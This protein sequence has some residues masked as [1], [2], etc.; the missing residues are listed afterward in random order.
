L[1]LPHKAVSQAGVRHARLGR[2]DQPVAGHIELIGRSTKLFLEILASLV[3]I[4]GIAGAVLAWRLSQGPISLGFLTPAVESAIN[5]GAGTQVD[6]GDTVLVWREARRTLDVRAIGVTVH[7]ADGRRLAQLP[8]VA[9]SLSARALLRGMIAPT[10]LDVVGARITLTRSPDGSFGLS[11]GEPSAEDRSSAEDSTSA[12]PLLLA[13]LLHPPDPERSMGYLQEVSV[14]E[15]EVTLFDQGTG[16][17]WRAPNADVVMTR[18][19]AGIRAEATLVIDL[20]GELTRVAATALYLAG[21]R[22]IDV[23]A[24]TTP[25]QP[26]TLAAIDP[27]L[28]GLSA[29]RVPISGKTQ[30]RL[31][32]AGRLLGL[33]FDIAGSAGTL[34]EPAYFTSDIA[35][36]RLRIR[37]AATAGL[38]RIDIVEGLLDLGGPT[39]ELAAAVADLG[40]RPRVTVE[41]AVRRLPTNELRKLWPK[42]AAEN[43]RVWVT[44]NLS[45]GTVE[46]TRFNV[47]LT[48]HDASFSAVDAEHVSLQFRFSG[49]EV[50][51]LSPMPRVRDV[52]GTG[53]MGATRLDLTVTDGGIDSLRVSEGKIAITDFE[54]KD[55]H[56]EI[57]LIVRGPVQD[58]MKLVDSPPL[59][60]VKTIGLSP[61][62][63]GGD[64][65]T[66]LR[67]R[68]PLVNNLKLDQL[69][70]AAAANIA[71]FTQRRAVLGQDITDGTLVLRLD[72][73]GM[74]ISGTVVAAAA[75]AEIK[76][77]RNFLAGAPVIA[78][79]RAKVT[80]DNAARRAFGLDLGAYVDGPVGTDLVYTEQRGRRSDLAVDLVL[81]G[82]ALDVPELEWRKALGAAGTAQLKLTLQNERLTEINS[83]R[84]AAG[85]LSAQGRATFAEDGK[86]LRRVDVERIKAG[87]TDAKGSYQR[88]DEGIA[89]RISG[90]SINVGPF[91]R[92]RTAGAANRPPLAVSVDVARVYLA[93]DRHVDR[94]GLEGRR[95]AE[96]WET[97]DLHLMAGGDGT[98]RNVGVA[99]RSEGAVQRLN[100]TADDA[101]ALLRAIG[102]TPNV[103]GGRLELRGESNPA[104]EGNPMVGNV[105]IR[106][107]RVVNAPVLARVLGIAL[108]TGIADSLRGEGIGFSILDADFVYL[109]PRIEIRNA[110]A[111]GAALGITASG[112]IDIGADTI[113]VNG[114]LV[115]AYAVNSLLGRIPVIGDVLV[116]GRGG[117]IFAANYQLRG[118]LENPE[119]SINPLSTL[120]PGFLRNLFG[121]GGTSPEGSAPLQAPSQSQ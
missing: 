74:D 20:A 75:P 60:F 62:D 69:Q 97:F 34:S 73:R 105:Q 18:D 101:G 57:E 5:A 114:T 93:A 30:F 65:A 102:I 81:T 13:E 86:T 71:N 35:I 95:S 120:A 100:A 21:E 79:T 43:G 38:D 2:Q 56:A 63:F 49:L 116:G 119:V 87:L 19:E 16:R 108:L 29:L 59:G 61:D 112:V 109:E 48:A 14:T 24:R 7:G 9:I 121:P 4:T 6:I 117:G 99:L 110:R 88:T 1:F 45:G 92:D 3:I 28:G 85:D 27:R 90:D 52:S 44:T 104:M 15:A 40:G 58:A 50:N 113:D 72:Q 64:S 8:E 94:V 84:V 32:P 41:G 107:F 96:R 36:R 25:F 106:T 53:K 33:E 83:M 26:A 77:T 89:V 23:S 37:G 10:R 66:R 17:V 118:S 115:P 80:L 46:E 47:G 76:M 39:I 78:Q 67:L 91:M 31:D 51:Y 103:V 54:K 98:A 70:V 111:S 68:F 42:G 82:A 12:L 11:A 55:Q 22:Q